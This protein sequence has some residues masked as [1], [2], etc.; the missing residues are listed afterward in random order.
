MGGLDPA[1]NSTV[2]LSGGASAADVFWTPSSAATFGAGAAFVG[3]IIDDA[4]IS[5]GAGA[6]L[7]GR[8]LAT[9]GTITTAGNAITVPGFTPPAIP[10]LSQWAMLLMATL[11][12][13]LTIVMIQRRFVPAR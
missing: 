10:T 13:G 5:F 12:V 7:N 2:A 6:T 11:L 8:A 3:T 9:G 4:G 1:I